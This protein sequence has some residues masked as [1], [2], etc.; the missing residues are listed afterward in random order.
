MSIKS[1][2]LDY[3]VSITLMTEDGELPTAD[4]VE[5]LIADQ[6]SGELDPDTGLFCGA[7]VLLTTEP[8]G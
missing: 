2:S 1:E 4:Q 3:I 7:V 6:M 5:G 8:K